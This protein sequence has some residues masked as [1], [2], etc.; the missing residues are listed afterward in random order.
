M[1]LGDFLSRQQGDNSNPH[2]IIPISFNMGKILQQKYQNY[3][4]DTFLVQIR[5][6]IKAK[7]TK[8]PDTCSGVKSLGKSRKEIKPIII[9]DGPTVIDLDTKTRI[10]IQMQD[11]TVTKTPDNLSRPGNRCMLYPDPT[12]R[13]LPKPPEFIDKRAKPTPNI[14]F[15]ENSPHQEGIISETYINLDQ[16]CF[17]KPQEL[18]HLVDTSKLVQKY[19]PIQ[20]DIDKILHIIK[21]KVLK[22][23][24]LPLTI[25]EI[26]AGYL[27]SLY[28]K[29]IYKYLAQNELPRKKACS[30][31][32][33]NPIRK[34]YPIGFFAIQINSNTWKREGTFGHTRGMHG[35]DYHA[36]SC[37]FVC[38]TT[39]CDKNLSNH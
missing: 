10:D 19:L 11:A 36:V 14:D 8:A 13:P 35:Q 24:H 37:I 7:N 3:T 33:Q 30:T 15:E 12:A 1:V 22:R 31:K 38:R 34:I 20:T 21:R 18:I 17:E 4:K 23:T 29:D 5:S 6:Q 26:Q 27:T 39:G 2:E 28:F 9:D 16:S 25:K 32:G